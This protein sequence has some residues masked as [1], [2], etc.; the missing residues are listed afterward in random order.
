MQ[1]SNIFNKLIFHLPNLVSLVFYN[2]LIILIKLFIN[3]YNKSSGTG[4]I[5]YFSF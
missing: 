5:K 3:Y 2:K 1:I 4:I